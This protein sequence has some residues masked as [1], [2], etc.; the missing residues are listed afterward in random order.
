METLTHGIS[1]LASDR[2]SFGVVMWE[3]FSFGA[4]PYAGVTNKD[5]YAHVTAGHR[6]KQPPGC[7]AS[8]IK[9]TPPPFCALLANTV[10]R[11]FIFAC[12]PDKG[13]A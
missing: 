13:C 4:R 3:V 6:L 2:W 7:P 11:K 5:L 9:C 8:A 12:R 1:T 10:W